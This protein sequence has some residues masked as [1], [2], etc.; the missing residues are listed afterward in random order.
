[1]F[2]KLSMTKLN[3]YSVVP[4]FTVF[5]YNLP[6]IRYKISYDNTITKVKIIIIYN[7]PQPLFFT[8]VQILKLVVQTII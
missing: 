4:L 2:K 3:W 5:L 1:M 7:T 8:V 6:P